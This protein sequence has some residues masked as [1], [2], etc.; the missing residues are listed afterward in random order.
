MDTSVNWIASLGY[1]IEALDEHGEIYTTAIYG[2]I[3]TLTTV[4]YGD[5]KAFNAHERVYAYVLMFAGILIFTYLVEKVKSVKSPKTVAKVL[6]ERN[7]IFID[8][9]HDIN[10]VLRGKSLDNKYFPDFYAQCETAAA[11]HFKHSTMIAFKESDF[12]R[13]L[14]PHVQERLV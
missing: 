2:S 12:Y 1:D 13:E 3:T 4:G 9:M 6:A 10:R 11:T 7:S 5:V 8:F 14:S